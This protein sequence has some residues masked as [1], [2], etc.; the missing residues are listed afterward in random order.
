MGTGK[1]RA[2]FRCGHPAVS[3]GGAGRQLSASQAD[4]V[5]VQFG[6]WRDNLIGRVSCHLP[7]PSRYL[8][9]PSTVCNLLWFGVEGKWEG[10]I[11]G[12]IAGSQLGR[13]AL[14]W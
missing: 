8:A 5:M 12:S 4:S 10:E 13:G 6:K 9:C 14:V 7:P 2:R 1:I 3:H 11:S